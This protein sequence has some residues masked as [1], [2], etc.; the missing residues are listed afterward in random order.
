MNEQ[1]ITLEELLALETEE[2]A[3]KVKELQEQ[4]KQLLDDGDLQPAEKIIELLQAFKD[5]KPKDNNKPVVSIDETKAE[6]ERNAQTKALEIRSMI[7]RGTLRG[8]S[9]SDIA[10][11]EAI[12]ALEVNNDTFNIVNH[13]TNIEMDASA[14]KLPTLNVKAE[15]VNVEEL[16][17]NPKIAIGE[18][19]L[20]ANPYSLDTFRKSLV[21]SEE[22]LADSGL[23]GQRL[24][25]GV[26]DGASSNTK[27]TEIKKAIETAKPAVTLAL[28]ALETALTSLDR[29]TAQILANKKNALAVLKLMDGHQLVDGE[30]LT[31]LWNGI[32]ITFIELPKENESILVFNKEDVKLV[33]TKRTPDQFRLIDREMSV[34]SFVAYSKALVITARFD[35]VITGVATSFTV[36]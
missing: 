4:A 18:L 28:E 9:T 19:E 20:S 10:I 22:M 7:G 31:V 23:N 1:L 15:L 12:N 6:E 35:V 27:L 8:I 17:D 24:V 32:R 29:G 2:Q 33:T 13:V 3:Q 34:A 14:G 16:A 21:F 30:N 26:A 11:P 36:A 5:K 25:T